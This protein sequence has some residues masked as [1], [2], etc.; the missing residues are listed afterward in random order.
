MLTKS[1]QRL[2]R[3]QFL[4][5]STV[6]AA[7]SLVGAC[8]PTATATPV[9]SNPTAMPAAT[10]APA[11]KVTISFQHWGNAIEAAGYKR[12]LDAFMAKVPNIVVQQNYV[13]DST[14]YGQK[15]LTSLAGGTGPDAFRVE[16]GWSSGL[17]ATQGSLLPLDSYISK[18]GIQLDQWV[19]G[20]KEYGNWNGKQFLLPIAAVGIFM[21]YNKDIFDAAKVPYPDKSWTFAQ[22]RDTALKLTQRDSSGRPTVY[23][24]QFNRAEQY[25]NPWIHQ[26]DGKT[27][28]RDISPKTCL[29]DDAKTAEALQFLAD[30]INVDKVSPTIADETAGLSV[31]SNGKIAMANCGSWDWLAFHD[32]AK[33]NW[34]VVTLPTNVGE[35]RPTL[36]TGQVAINSQTKSPDAA[37]ELLNYLTATEDGQ[38]VVSDAIAQAPVT[39]ALQMK[40]WQNTCDRLG[41]KN[42]M[43]VTLDIFGAKNPHMRPT[44][45]TY[46]EALN[47]VLNPGLEEIF[48]G[49]RTAAVVMAEAAPKITAILGKA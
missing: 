11:Q 32:Q 34:D 23:G 22:L 15:L 1:N 30:L 16:G 29:M 48:L 24:F 17:L 42:G 40:I 20:V 3:R 10:S 35:L 39:K 21:A 45:P 28:D 27:Y 31:F 19:P 46:T 26:N 37:W 4:K 47:T 33:F 36:W 43:V 12:V 18:A 44:G 14:T 13:A 38:T 9:A 6:V 5:L 25:L 8:S 2:S 7:G 41:A 49:R